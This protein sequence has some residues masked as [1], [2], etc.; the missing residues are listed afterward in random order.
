MII[1]MLLAYV[2]KYD[3]FTKELT[4]NLNLRKHL[5][6]EYNVKSLNYIHHNCRFQTLFLFY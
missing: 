6:L 1:H 4:Q 2:T 5:K 3:R